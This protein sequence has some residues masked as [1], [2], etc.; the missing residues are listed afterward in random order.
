LEGVRQI[1]G[2]FTDEYYKALLSGDRNADALAA[3]RMT[4]FSG[5]YKDPFYSAPLILIGESTVSAHLHSARVAKK[6][7]PVPFG[8]KDSRIFPEIREYAD[9]SL[10]ISDR[11]DSMAERGDSNFSRL[12]G[13][14]SASGGSAEAKSSAKS[15]DLRQKA[16]K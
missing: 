9:L 13:V 1:N 7:S 3:A 10:S 12:Q 8:A 14:R 2:Q 4:L 15:E 11:I 16:T 5:K 6:C